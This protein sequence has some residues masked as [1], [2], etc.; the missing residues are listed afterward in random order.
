MQAD[1][2]VLTRAC[3]R[4][5]CA[6]VGWATEDFRFDVCLSH[7]GRVP[8]TAS[9]DSCFQEVSAEQGLQNRWILLSRVEDLNLNFIQVNDFMTTTRTALQQH[10][11]ERFLL[12]C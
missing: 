2:V 9:F 8:P 5:K 6:I 4:F 10:A 3:W 11:G 1:M 7:F 12:S